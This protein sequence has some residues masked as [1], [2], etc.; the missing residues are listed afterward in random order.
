MK[1]TERCPQCGAAYV[2]TGRFG[3]DVFECDTICLAG[4]DVLESVECLQRQRGA[5]KDECERLEALLDRLVVMAATGECKRRADGECPHSQ[6]RVYAVGSD[7]ERRNWQD[8]ICAGCIRLQE[9]GE[10]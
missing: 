8:G 9:G 1:P 7:N 5:L 4:G 2:S 3:D 10:S 6:A